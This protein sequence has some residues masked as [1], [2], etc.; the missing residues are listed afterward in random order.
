MALVFDSPRNATVQVIGNMPVE[1]A[2]LES[3]HFKN[4]AVTFKNESQHQLLL[5][6]V[7]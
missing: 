1:L 6:A 3:V 7:K 5:T 2:I 4:G